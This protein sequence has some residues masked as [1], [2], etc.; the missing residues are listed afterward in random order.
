VDDAAAE[1]DVAAAA[2]DPGSGAADDHELMWFAVQELR[3][4]VGGDA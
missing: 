3:H 1:A 4:L 2:A